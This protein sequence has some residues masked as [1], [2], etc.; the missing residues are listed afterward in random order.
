MVWESGCGGVV[1]QGWGE[2]EGLRDPVEDRH[3]SV[4]TC[5]STGNQRRMVPDNCGHTL[6]G[7]G[8]LEEGIVRAVACG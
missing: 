3:L 7:G 1:A 8:V 5:S 2:A 4:G 6:W